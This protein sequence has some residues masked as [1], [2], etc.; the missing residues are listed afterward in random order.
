MVTPYPP[1]P[2]GI[3]AYAVQTVRRLRAEGHHVEA[4]SPGPSAAHHHLNLLG[5]RGALAL[6]KRMRHYDRVIVQFHPEFYFRPPFT[7][8]ALAAESAALTVAF[9]AARHLEVRVHEIDYR[10]GEHDNIGARALRT[11]WRSV[12]V[13]VV[14]TEA[15]KRTFIDAFGVRPDRVEVMAHGMDFDRHTTATREEARQALGLPLD[16]HCFLAIGFVQPHKG[17]DRAIRAFA[18]LGTSTARLDIVGGVRVEHREHVDYAEALERQADATPGAH[19]HLGLLSD[20]AFD[21]WIVAADTV[22]LP[23]RSIWSSG[24]MERAHLYGVPVIATNVGGLA[25][26]AGDRAGLVIVDDDEELV[27]AMARSAGLEGTTHESWKLG[28]TERDAIQVEIVR[29]A[30]SVRGGPAVVEVDGEPAWVSAGRDR[31]SA[32]LRRLPAY[33]PGPVRRGRPGTHLIR[34]VV[35]RLVA[36]ELTPI[37][38]QVNALQH[39]TIESVDR[40]A[41]DDELPSGGPPPDQRGSNPTSRAID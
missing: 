30:R 21:R 26:Q 14:H 1:Q 34:R 17:F 37:V 29:R 41:G 5:P 11:M 36:A 10:W 22:V 24:V 31:A 9:R 38:E 28:V 32:P 7:P 6:A 33:V 3:G 8:A 39:W 18:Q 27:R 16:R 4:L 25:E 13:I 19:V 20:E 23:Y 2:D 35:R 12:D 40:A 15:E